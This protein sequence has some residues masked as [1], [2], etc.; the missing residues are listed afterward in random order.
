MTNAISL[1]NTLVSLLDM[2]DDEAWGNIWSADAAALFDAHHPELIPP[3]RAQWRAWSVNRQDH[4]AFLL[5]STGTAEE[6]ALIREMLG[7]IDPN[8]ASRARE[9]L[10]EFRPSERN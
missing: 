10:N 2:P 8:V 3:I 1:L 6:E 5:G 4:L 7:A 9:A